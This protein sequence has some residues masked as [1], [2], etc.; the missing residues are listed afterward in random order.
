MRRMLYKK[1]KWDIIPM[2]TGELMESL[3]FCRK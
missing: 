1:K 3:L 2:E